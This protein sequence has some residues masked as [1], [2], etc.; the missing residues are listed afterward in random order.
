M[1]QKQSKKTQ[2]GFAAVTLI[3]FMAIATTITAAATSIVITNNLSAS[4]E[5]RSLQAYYL[6]ESG[7][8]EGLLNYLRNPNYIGT[9]GFINF[10]D[11]VISIGV[12]SNTMTSIARYS[13]FERKISTNLD[14]TDNL[15]VSSWQEVF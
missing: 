1:T 13:G 3:V 11:G 4:K 15:D 8:E 2:F 9:N 5:A 10:G 12:N 7:L 14:Y 6:A